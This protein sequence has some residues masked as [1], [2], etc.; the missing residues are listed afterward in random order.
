MLRLLSETGSISRAPRR[1]D[2][3]GSPEIVLWGLYSDD[4]HGESEMIPMKL[5]A[6]KGS[7]RAEKPSAVRSSVAPSEDSKS[8]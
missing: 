2:V 7:D 4:C 3:V 5:P 1:N 6:G 8:A